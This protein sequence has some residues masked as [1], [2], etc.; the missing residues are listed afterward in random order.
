MVLKLVQ[1]V[2][3]HLMWDIWWE[4]QYQDKISAKLLCI[5]VSII[6]IVLP[7]LSSVHHRL[8][9]ISTN[10]S[11]FKLPTQSTGRRSLDFWHAKRHFYT[12]V[13]PA[14][15]STKATVLS[16]KETCL[17]QSLLQPD[18]PEV[19]VYCRGQKF[20]TLR[21]LFSPVLKARCF[22]KQFHR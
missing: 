19:P 3:G 13:R 11:V 18:P 7:S 5:P 14:V 21:L 8:Y 16:I 22:V 10:D 6:P 15:G 1:Y 17:L 9:I 4:K 20:V 12:A 2:P